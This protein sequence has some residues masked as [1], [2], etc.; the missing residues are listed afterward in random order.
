MK[1]VVVLILAVVI[2]VALVACGGKIEAQSENNVSQITSSVVADSSEQD[3]I[4]L[5]DYAIGTWERHFTTSDGEEVTQVM[6]IYK[7]GTGK[8]IIYSNNDGTFHAT[9]ETQDDVLNFT[10]SSP[11]TATYGFILDAD[12]EVITLTRVDDS[13]VIFT[14]VVE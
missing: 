12:S 11:V 5:K 10:Y 8:F 14:K 3:V 13:T 7:G 6:E 9:W 1:K 2:C 4:E